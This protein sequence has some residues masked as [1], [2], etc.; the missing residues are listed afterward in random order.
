L[1]QPIAFTVTIVIVTAVSIIPA[2]V[3]KRI[4]R[5]PGTGGRLCAPFMSLFIRVLSPAIRFLSFMADRVLAL[6]PIRAAPA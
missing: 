3:P 1:A 2:V 4:A 6:L 5:P